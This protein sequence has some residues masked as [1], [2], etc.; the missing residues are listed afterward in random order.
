MRKKGLNLLQSIAYYILLI[1]YT[2][3]RW[4]KGLNLSGC[5][6]SRLYVKKVKKKQKKLKAALVWLQRVEQKGY[7]LYLPS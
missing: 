4:T 7:K 5:R 1:A 2:V 6:D 3:D